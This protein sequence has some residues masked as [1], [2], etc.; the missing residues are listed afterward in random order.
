MRA[1]LLLSAF[2]LAAAA[3]VSIQAANMPPA[4]AA[5]IL[6]QAPAPEQF[7]QEAVSGTDVGPGLVEPEL[8]GSPSK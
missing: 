7:L 3:V 5:A 6:E 1:S 4:Q 8:A 2:V